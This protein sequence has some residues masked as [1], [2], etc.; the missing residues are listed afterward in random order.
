LHIREDALAQILEKVLYVEDSALKWDFK[1]LAREIVKHGTTHTPTNRS[2]TITNEK[3]YDKVRRLNSAPRNLTSDFINILHHVRKKHNRYVKAIMPKPGSNDYN[4]LKEVAIDAENFCKQFN[5]KQREGFI[6]YCDMAIVRMK[7]FAYY[8]MKNMYEGI[9]NAYTASQA[10]KDNPDADKVN[11]ICHYYNQ[12]ILTRTGVLLFDYRDNP[13]KY[14]YFIM[15]LKECNR[16][17]IPSK[18]Y[19][20]AQF[21]AF[22][23]RGRYP[24]P[25]QLVGDKALLRV[26]QYMAENEIK[27][28]HAKNKNNN[29]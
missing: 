18:I 13:E 5:L 7:K 17:K 9:C 14:Q 4:L 28:V 29:K 24:E 1:G 27:L 11:R 25:E 15:V 6:I 8:K 22:E 16:L 10:L 3:L 20:D 23:F 26:Q 19:M 12:Q 21:S 2:I